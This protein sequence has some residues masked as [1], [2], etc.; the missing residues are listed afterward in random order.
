MLNLPIDYNT[1]KKNDSQD[2]C[3]KTKLKHICMPDLPILVIL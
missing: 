2:K 1:K 3:K